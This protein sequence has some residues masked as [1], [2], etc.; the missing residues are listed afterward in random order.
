LGAALQ[1]ADRTKRALADY[2]LANSL[3][4]QGEFTQRSQVMFNLREELKSTQEMQSAIRDISEMLRGSEALTGDDY[5]LLRQ[6]RPMVDDVDFRR[7]LGIPEALNAWVW[8]SARRASWP[9]MPIFAMVL[10]HASSSR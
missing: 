9:P 6:K 8:P 4:A 3:G 7:L 10:T 2:A 1:E 5:A